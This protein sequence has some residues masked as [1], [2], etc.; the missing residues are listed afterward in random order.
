MLDER[1]IRRLVKNA[2][3]EDV[4]SGDIT[5]SL[6]Q[7]EQQIEAVIKTR[8][9]MVVAGCEFVNE[10]FQQVNPR[11]KL[12]WQVEDGNAITAETTLVK[13]KGPAQSLLTAERVALNF[14]QLLSGV[15]TVTRNYVLAL[16]DT[17]AQLLDTRKTIPGLRAAQKYAVTCG[18]GYNHRFGLFDAYL[19]KENHIRACGTISEVI[20]KARQIH[21]NKIVEIEVENLSQFDQAL[22]AGADI[23]MCDNFSMT[24]LRAAVEHSEGRAKIE[25]S[26][27]MSLQRIREVAKSGVDYIS[28]GALTKNIQ[29]IDL[30]M[31][32]LS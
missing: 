28:V 31:L 4:G 8:E 13:L 26:G 6:I 3:V 10:V 14:L 11:V 25:A 7:P 30:T 24:E 17:K 21:G 12:Q 2:L 9:A 22:N 19:I 23:I 18:G 32:F 16:R 27:N 1:Y 29:A 20:K 5:A 15:A